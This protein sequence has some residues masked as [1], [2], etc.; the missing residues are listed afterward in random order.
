MYLTS[1]AWVLLELRHSHPPQQL[2][3]LVEAKINPIDNQRQQT[4]TPGPAQIGSIPPRRQETITP[5]PA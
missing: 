2:T 5:G 3:P 4:I 1:K